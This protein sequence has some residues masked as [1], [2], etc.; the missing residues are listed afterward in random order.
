MRRQLFMAASVAVLFVAG[1]PA[2]SQEDVGS[3]GITGVYD[4]PGGRDYGFE[5]MKADTRRKAKTSDELAIGADLVKQEKF[6]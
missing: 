3:A 6:A 2:F 4:R 5:N 1:A